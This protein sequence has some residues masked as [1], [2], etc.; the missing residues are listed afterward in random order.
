MPDL[1]EDE[2]VYNEDCLESDLESAASEFINS[3]SDINGC[4][5]DG[6][7]DQMKKV[8]VVCSNLIYNL[9]SNY[10]TKY[11]R[12]GCLIHQVKNPFSFASR[13][14]YSLLEY[15]DEA[16]DHTALKHTRSPKFN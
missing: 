7:M 6:P 10:H 14:L 8:C 15:C 3:L 16:Y 13:K 2:V 9:Y 1:D 4:H 11:V 5:E 12:I